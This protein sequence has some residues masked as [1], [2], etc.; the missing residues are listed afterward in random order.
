MKG[1]TNFLYHYGIDGAEVEAREFPFI[2]SSKRPWHS[3]SKKK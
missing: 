1:Y 2:V 3:V